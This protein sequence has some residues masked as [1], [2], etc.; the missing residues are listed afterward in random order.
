M[1]PLAS[2][3]KVFGDPTRLRMLRL[4]EAEELSAGEVA[5]SLGMTQSRISNQ[6]RILREAHLVRERHAGA[7]V[8]LRSALRPGPGTNGGLAL[9]RRLWEAM[10]EE[11]DRLPER[12]LDA[13]RLAEVLAERSATSRTFFDGVAG[14]WDEVGG[15]FRSGQARQRVAARLMPADLVLADLGC[16][17]G[18]FAE[19]LLGL[20]RRLILVDSSPRMLEEAERRLAARGADTVVEA[21]A[22]ELDRLP[23]ADAELDGVVAGMVLHH[24]ATPDAALAEMRRVVRP[25][26]TA[27]VL[28]LAPHREQWMHEALGDRHLGLDPELVAEG[29]RDAG[30]E[31]V[32]LEMVEDRYCP[33]SPAEGATALPVL[34]LYCIRGRVPGTGRPRSPTNP[35][36]HAS[37]R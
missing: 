25:G 31:D 33:R 3:I 16:G 4:L 19:A 6:L 17:T 32:S 36:L 1:A 35:T 13:T 5:R 23:I 18:Y 9:E 7:S 29:L 24:L 26:G 12:G 21:R 20:C 37:E 2:L 22:G 34:P 27:V 11:L 30:F 8:F 15:R 10:R 14:R 28:E